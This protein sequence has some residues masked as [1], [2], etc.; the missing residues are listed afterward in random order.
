MYRTLL[1]LLLLAPAA[2]A[3]DKERAAKN[4]KVLLL[5]ELAVREQQFCRNLFI[6]EKEQARA[7]VSIYRQQPRKIVGVDDESALEQFPS[8][9]TG[10]DLTKKETLRDNLGWYDLVIAFDPNW[11]ELGKSNLVR[12]RDWVRDHGGVLVVVAGQANFP[13]L[14][15]AKGEERKTLQ[16]ILDLLPVLP[17]EWEAVPADAPRRLR[18]TQAA[19]DSSFLRLEKP[20][21]ALS[22]WETFFRGP[23]RKGRKKPRS[24]GSSGAIRSRASNV[25][26]LSWRQLITR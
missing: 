6:R 3:A 1:C 20:E 16:P 13:R 5:S 15:D 26:R 9:L 23:G 18:F 11:T 25:T 4:C 7:D 24:V 22:G 21:E 8:T 14:H 2:L 10:V 12:L 19:R 17:G